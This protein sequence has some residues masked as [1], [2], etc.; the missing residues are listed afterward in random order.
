MMAGSRKN[1]KEKDDESEL[2]K[3]LTYTNKS[4]W[5]GMS[6]GNARKCYSFSRGYMDFLTKCKTET[7]SVEFIEEMARKAGYTDLRDRKT[8]KAGDLVYI[9]NRGKNI[10]LFRVGRGPLSGGL[11]IIAAHVDCPRL[12]LK[13]S[14]LSQD[15]DSQ[16]A[17]FKTHYYGGIKKYQWVNIPL[18]LQGRVVKSD[19]TEVDVRIGEGKGDPV[20]VVPD[21]LPHLA[22]R[23]NKRN[24]RTGIKGEELR[25]IAGSRP[26]EDEKAKKK[27]KLMVLRELN[28]RY[29]IVEE[30]LVSS[31]LELVPSGPARDVGLDRSLV[32]GY[33]QDD[34][35]CAYASVK[36]ILD[37]GKEKGK[38]KKKRNEI[39]ERTAACVL[40]D[41]EEVGSDGPTGVKS[42]FL[43]NAVGELMERTEKNYREIE[44]RR[45]LEGSYALSADV[46]GAINPVFKDVHEK[47]NAAVLGKGIVITKY[48]GSGGKYNSSEASPSFV[49]KIRKILNDEGISWQTGELGK[50]DEGGGGTVAKYLALHNMDVLDA[51]TAIVSMHSPFE[52]SSKAD[53]YSSYL[54]YRAFFGKMK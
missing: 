53:V 28:D 39:P 21:L 34:R 16:T 1:R 19:G 12:D 37:M 7:Q 44:L 4:T 22:A 48:T 51:G 49:A 18:S 25:A 35:V 26:V 6:K 32:G 45:A 38:G 33:G 24:L 15:E 30:D 23:Q 52:I 27:L 20:L 40:F 14:P 3:S 9:K 29:G 31:D 8:I 11:N 46:N 13:P 47:Q 43:L 42:R 10:I 50:V 41:R 5:E 2:E 54:A 36:A 17:L